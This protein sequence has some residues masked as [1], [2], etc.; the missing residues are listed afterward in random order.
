[1]H[2]RERKRGQENGFGR[3]SECEKYTNIYIVDVRERER[4]RGTC[5]WGEKQNVPLI[6]KYIS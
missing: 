2:E 3:L 5:I 4:E 1:M 6:A